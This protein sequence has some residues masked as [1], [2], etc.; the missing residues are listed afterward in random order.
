MRRVAGL[1]GLLVASLLV[2]ALLAEWVARELRLSNMGTPYVRED[3][4]TIYS[5]TPLKAGR[6]TSPG[7]FSI[8]FAIN[9]NGLRS[10]ESAYEK[11]GAQRVLA[12]GD[13]FTFGVGAEDDETWPAHLA[14]GLAETGGDWEVL[15]AGVQGWGLA[16]YLIWLENEGVRYGPDWIVIG[17]HAGDWANARR[18][19]LT[20]ED[21]G[22]LRH[23]QVTRHQVG[24]LKELSEQIPFY[25][26]LVTHSSFANFLKYRIAFL[27]DWGTTGALAEDGVEDRAAQFRNAWPTNRAILARIAEI[28]QESGARVAMVFI[29]THL[30]LAGEASDPAEDVFARELESAAAEEG[31]A[32]VNLAPR[33]RGEIARGAGIAD[34]YFLLDGHCR[35][36]GYAEIA[37]AA[38][39]AMGS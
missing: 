27:L 7:E 31:I 12:L 6:M 15:N 19:L 35:P 30:A 9:S 2:C 16:E 13:S 25:E 39:E 22:E 18:G 33:L 5:N 37:D 26:L 28:A 38:R 21:S 11:T 1:I 4:D 8:S 23:H 3:P 24:R 29:P 20:L 34:Y 32:F 17:V 10:P 36:A 14:A